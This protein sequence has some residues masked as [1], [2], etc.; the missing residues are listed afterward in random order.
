M[1]F[2][3]PAVFIV[4]VPVCVTLSF[5]LCSCFLTQLCCSLGPITMCRHSDISSG[6]Y[7][8]RRQVQLTLVISI[9]LGFVWFSSLVRVYEQ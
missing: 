5:S 8:L 2:C 7:T 9:P 1:R 4:T 3:W 6:N